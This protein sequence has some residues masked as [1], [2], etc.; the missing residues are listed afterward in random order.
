MKI[1]KALVKKA[2]RKLT[3]TSSF[4]YVKEYNIKGSKPLKPIPT[5]FDSLWCKLRYGFDTKEYFYFDLYNKSS[6]DRRSFVSSAEVFFTVSNINKGSQYPFDQKFSTYQAFEPYYR[7]EAFTLTLPDESDK[8]IAFARKHGGF[9]IKPLSLSQGRGI[10]LWRQDM[11]DAENALLSICSLKMKGAIVEELIQ[12]DEEMASFHPSSIN[13]IRYT[14]DYQDGYVDRIYAMIRLGVGNS[15]VDN[16]SAGGICAAIDLETGIIVSKGF[17][18]DGKQ[19]IFHPD[20]GK[21][22]IGTKIPKWDELNE[23]IDRIRPKDTTVH[24]VGWD[25]ALSKDGWCVVE[26]NW[27]PAIIGIQASSGVGYRNALLRAKKNSKKK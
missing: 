17:R 23:T 6:R 10:C 5:Y 4:K 19:F 18:R 7:R 16:T 25:M 26:G 15:Q 1:T 24:F 9:I 12:Q 22:I 20:S 3:D 27:C 14:V 11:D 8:L 13:T 2:F 21:Q